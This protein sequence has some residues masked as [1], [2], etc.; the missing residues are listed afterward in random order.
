MRALDYSI[1]EL[2][3]ETGV[4]VPTIR[5]YEGVGLLPAPPRTEGNQRRYDDAALSR[6]RFVAH[7]R[8]MGFPMDELRAMLRI[9]GHKDS[10]CEDID[11]L[12]R[13]RLGE[14]EER[15]A[16]LTALKSELSGMLAS[17]CHGTVGECRVV[18]VL[19]DHERCGHE[20]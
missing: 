6:L 16:R 19:S 11:A 13:A 15:I 1:G 9:A 17:G 8:A 3:A 14:I 4:K 20:H 5:Y 18:E 12:V 10:P 2:A 7:A